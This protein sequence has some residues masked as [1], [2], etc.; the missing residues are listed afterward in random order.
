LQGLEPGLEFI[1][2]E[3]RDQ[4]RPLA[5]FCPSLTGNLISNPDT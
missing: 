1:L 5:T 2:P 4:L 3:R